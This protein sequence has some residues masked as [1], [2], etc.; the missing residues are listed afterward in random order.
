M[1][2]QKYKSICNCPHG[3]KAISEVNSMIS[4]CFNCSSVIFKY[5]S[6]KEIS[7]IKPSKFS[8]AQE[9]ATPIFLSILDTHKPYNF[10]N[11]SDY[12]KIRNIF[13]KKIKLFCT[14]LNISKKTYFLTIDYFDRVCSKLLAFDINDLLQISQLCL[15]LAAK[16]CETQIK[17]I[18]IKKYLNLNNNYSQ[19]ELY[20]LQLLDYDLYAHTSY[21]I[22][23]DIMH[24]GFLFADEKFSLKKMNFL[25]GKM[26]NM[27][28]FFSEKNFY[29]EMTQK[30]IALSIIGL[31]REILGLIAYNNI[32]KNIFMNE[33]AN[34]QS[35]YACLKKLRK[36][37]KIKDKN[38]HT[39]S[40]TDSNSD[41]NSDNISENNSKID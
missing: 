2:A 16:F 37:F 31:I 27:L 17:T 9:T 7:T 3:T 25:Y 4:L 41:N 19:D 8:V 23:I 33:N 36:C 35:Y 34:I 32:L 40:S 6:Y 15:I 30:E 20:I 24:T 5:D 39:Y 11:K 13:I 14:N 21:D 1:Q 18:E 22:L 38:E 26:E 12:Q 29:I 28:F 10:R